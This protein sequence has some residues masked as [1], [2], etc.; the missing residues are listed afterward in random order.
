VAVNFPPKKVVEPQPVDA[1]PVQETE[2]TEN[3]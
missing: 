1:E 3:N 2:S